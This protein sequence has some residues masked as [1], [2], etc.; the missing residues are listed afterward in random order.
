M[1]FLVLPVLTCVC[2]FAAC[3]ASDPTGPESGTPSASPADPTGN[4]AAGLLDECIPGPEIC[5]GID[6][7]CDGLVD[8]F[9][10]GCETAEVAGPPPHDDSTYDQPVPD[11]PRGPEGLPPRPDAW[12]EGCVDEDGDLVPVCPRDPGFTQDCD[13]L[14]DSIHPFAP[15][16]CDGIDNNCNGVIDEGITGCDTAEIPGPPPHDEGRD[17]P[18]VPTP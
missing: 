10:T 9:I 8:E 14:D 17:T 7:D 2:L 12:P 6:N 18:P 5:D 13:D 11:A 1:K 16:F 4:A 3:D 15:E